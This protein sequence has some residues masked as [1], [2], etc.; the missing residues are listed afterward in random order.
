MAR[1]GFIVGIADL[2]IQQF[3]HDTGASIRKLCSGNLAWSPYY[4]TA[5]DP[6]T[7][8]PLAEFLG[9]T[10]VQNPCALASDSVSVYILDPMTCRVLRIA[11]KSGYLHSTFG[12]K[13]GIGTGRITPDASLRSIIARANGDTWITDNE[14]DFLVRYTSSV[15]DL[16]D[17]SFAAEYSIAGLS[18][19]AGVSFDQITGFAW[20]EARSHYWALAS[21]SAAT[22]LIEL[23]E[24]LSFHSAIN[25]TTVAGIAGHG[26]S[27]ALRSVTRGLYYAQGDLFLWSGAN[28]YRIDPAGPSSTVVYTGTSNVVPGWVSADASE[29]SA[30][31]QGELTGVNSLVVVTSATGATRSYCP[32]DNTPDS[33]VGDACQPWHHAVTSYTEDTSLQVAVTVQARA[34]IRNT[35]VRTAESRANIRATTARTVQARAHIILGTQRIVTARARIEEPSSI[36]D[37]PVLAWSVDH[38]IDQYSAGFDLQV[39]S[40]TGFQIGNEVTIYAGYDNDRLKII[41][42]QVENT[43]RSKSGQQTT[44]SVS[45][46]SLGAALDRTPITNHWDSNPPND[47]PFA[48]DIVRDVASVVGLEV[49]ALEF[50]NYPLYNSLSVINGRVI[51]VISQLLEPWNQFTRIKYAPVIK[52]GVLHVLKIDWQNPPDNG[53]IVQGAYFSDLQLNQEAYFGEPD[54]SNVSVIVI[55]GAAYTVPRVN[56]GTQTRIEYT[57]NVTSGDV[58]ESVFGSIQEYVQ[59]ETVVTETVFGDKVIHR[60]EKVYT[61]RGQLSVSFGVPELTQ[62]TIDTFFYYEPGENA[63]VMPLSGDMINYQRTVPSEEALLFCSTSKRYGLVDIAVPDGDGGTTDISRLEHLEDGYTIYQ[64]DAENQVACECSVSIQWTI[65]VDGETGHVTRTKEPPRMEIRTHSQTTGGTVRTQLSQFTFEESK[66]VRDSVNV[67]Q[68]GGTRPDFNNPGSRNNLRSVQVQAPQGTFDTAG[69]PVDLAEGQT[70]W[71]YEN[72]Y[73]GPR[74]VDAIYEEALREQVF[75]RA[76]FKW[77]RCPFTSTLNPNIYAGQAIKIETEA[78]G[79]EAFW[80]EN[81]KHDYTPN[82]AMTSGMASRLTTEDL[83]SG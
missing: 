20:D 27:P 82:S 80:V 57:R 14:G 75:Q 39:V 32:A 6:T 49:G 73:L 35:V 37:K 28:V 29:F 45:G 44:F 38:A 5:F 40:P 42:G 52:N 55:K 1:Y 36:A 4:V 76:G 71:T 67:Q 43:G 61:S 65:E 25:L 63:S 19:A 7:G 13:R 24:D 50:P 8:L 18:S 10:D 3:N 79:F 59:V 78:D 17:N 81:V 22:F 34:S 74:E 64:Y 77:E 12:G 2:T 54:L 69:N 70:A 46:R 58:L 62:H 68:V 23:D 72:P 56:L 66:F 26:G 31:L 33:D 15:E 41:K 16:A 21:G 48:H 11:A 47:T 83:S 53:Y 30:T 9:A 51:S 60:D